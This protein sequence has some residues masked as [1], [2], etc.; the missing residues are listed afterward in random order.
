MNTKRQ[1]KI[2]SSHRLEKAEPVIDLCKEFAEDYIDRLEAYLHVKGI[3]LPDNR[4]TTIGWNASD[5]QF[6]LRA[7]MNLSTGAHEM[8]MKAK[9]FSQTEMGI[10]PKKALVR[11]FINHPFA[12]PK[13]YNHII[14]HEDVKALD[15]ELYTII[16][17]KREEITALKIQLQNIM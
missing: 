12:S 3:R 6:M 8:I 2:S 17:Q 4:V 10:L 7:I 5:Q 15:I 11:Y 14:W 9:E 13:F 1:S 16:Q